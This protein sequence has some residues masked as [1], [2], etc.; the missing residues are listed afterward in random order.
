M[1]DPVDLS[2]LTTE[3]KTVDLSD[4]F[5]SN[6]SPLRQKP[7]FKGEMTAKDR[8]YLAKA[9]KPNMVDRAA[10][11]ARAANRE[12]IPTGGALAG[13]TMGAEIGAFGG[14]LAPV[15]VPLGGLIGALGG[16]MYAKHLQNT[17]GEAAPAIPR[18]LG[19]SPER[20][21]L[22]EKL[23]PFATTAGSFAPSLVGGNELQRLMTPKGSKVEA[24]LP[25]PKTSR[26]AS[27]RDRINETRMAA[28]RQGVEL[29]TSLTSPTGY[30]LSRVLPTA[31]GGA[32]L[33]KAEEAAP[34][35]VG[36]RIK[37]LAEVYGK[38]TE[39]GAAGEAM[40]SSANRWMEKA[41]K[42]GGD[43]I[44]MSYRLAGDTQLPPTSALKSVDEKLAMLEGNETVNRP[45]IRSLQ[46]IRA[47]MLADKPMT[48]QRLHDL[49]Q[50]LYR[51]AQPEGMDAGFKAWL[52][53][54]LYN[55]LSTDIRAG[56]NVAADAGDK[57][58]RNA[59]EAFDTGSETW[60]RRKNVYNRALKKVLG[61]DMVED[62]TD[63]ARPVLIA[64]KSPEA[65][66][67]AV[68]NMAGNDRRAFQKT[69]SALD[70]EAQDTVRA[71]VIASLGRSSDG[72]FSPATFLSDMH[73]IP[74]QTRVVLFG[75]ENMAAMD[76]LQT[77]VRNI[78]QA[79]SRPHGLGSFGVEAAIAGLL[80]LHAGGP[81][82]AAMTFP[83]VAGFNYAAARFLAKPDSLKWL[84]R[85]GSASSQGTGAV[86]EAVTELGKAASNRGSLMPLYE[87]MV[88]AMNAKPEEAAA[89]APPAGFDPSALT[90]EELDKARGT[91]G[92]A[93]S[94]T[95]GEVDPNVIEAIK[96]QEG[97]G[98]NPKSTAVGKGQF[99]D[100]TFV[101]YAK[102]LYPEEMKGK[103]R[104]EILSYRNAQ[105]EGSDQTIE[106][107]LL[108]EFTKDNGKVL[109]EIGAESSPANLYL[110]HFFG[111]GDVQKVL[112]ADPTTPIEDV[113]SNAVIAA[114][115]SIL[116]GK[117]VGDVISWA[118]DMMSKRMGQ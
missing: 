91:D 84:A 13:G 19:Q 80:G 67:E 116:K 1:P 57:N 27:T 89:E 53:G 17:V 34:E 42:E 109:S 18:A 117:R 73:K 26:P 2:D 14:P 29:P 22:D 11:F 95:S 101:D 103:S 56:L 9:T 110:A 55:A 20:V 87:T 43:L 54:D 8:A 66:W 5:E 102:K 35:A 94:M 90:D 62:L 65:A 96:G 108:N 113:V 4:L 45:L 112:K 97:T 40:Q 71:S 21:A 111:P 49:R 104:A 81:G 105:I 41:R 61:S 100:D 38:P 46:E 115:A 60:A 82:G 10:A 69:M 68:R 118:S 33:G 3:T 106:D 52:K 99:L 77:I 59:L 107:Y 15:T 25:S 72:S 86:N 16:G 75:K 39:R 12:I 47:D 88:R 6:T 51:V 30:K 85:L 36:A 64:E 32:A 24:F 93:A 79:E 76:D 44:E 48:L 114:N 7:G 50:S 28:E 74:V 31:V 92:E 58:A 70:P 23:Y 37:Q 63:P 83:A 78:S 98:D